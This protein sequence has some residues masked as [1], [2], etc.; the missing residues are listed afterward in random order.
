MSPSRPLIWSRLTFNVKRYIENH[1]NDLYLML[2]GYFSWF[3]LSFKSFFL[4]PLLCI[5]KIIFMIHTLHFQGYTKNFYW[6]FSKPYVSI[7]SCNFLTP[8]HDL[9]S[10]NHTFFKPLTWFY[11]IDYSFLLHLASTRNQVV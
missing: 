7:L 9:Y 4:W 6:T 3:F 11:L 2:Y 10:I 1:V 5:F 8:S